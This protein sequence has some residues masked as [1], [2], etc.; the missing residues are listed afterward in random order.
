MYKFRYLKN[1]S[2]TIGDVICSLDEF[3]EI[4][5]EFDVADFGD[6]DE[7][8]Y[9]QDG[10]KLQITD[11]NQL[12]Y[13]N[14]KIDGWVKKESYYQEKLDV[15][16]KPKPPTLEEAKEAKIVQIKKDRD[17]DLYKNVVFNEREYVASEKASS[18][19]TGAVVILMASAGNIYPWLDAEGNSISLT[20]DELV[21]LGNLIAQQKGTSYAKEAT[22]VKQVND[23]NS[24]EEVYNINW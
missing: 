15:L 8:R 22:L 17:V 16:R 21:T 20:K 10:R 12:G 1:K 4:E 7:I 11:A 6:I 19:I 9:L 2:I 18:N 14:S 13:Q 23:A 3:S 24:V 5:I